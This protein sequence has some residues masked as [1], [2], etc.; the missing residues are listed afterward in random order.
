VSEI[1]HHWVTTCDNVGHG[2]FCS[3]CESNA[4]AAVRNDPRFGSHTDNAAL[5]LGVKVVV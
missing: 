3:L 2:A 1:H 5:H 4:D